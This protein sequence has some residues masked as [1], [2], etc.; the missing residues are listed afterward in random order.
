M[1]KN[2]FEDFSK[3][4]D[5][6]WKEKIEDPKALIPLLQAYIDYDLVKNDFNLSM[7]LNEHLPKHV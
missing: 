4:S 7:D 2:L 1:Q 3:V 5:Q 6:E